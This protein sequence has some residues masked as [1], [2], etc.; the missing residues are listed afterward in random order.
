M[1]RTEWVIQISPNLAKAPT[2]PSVT[3]GPHTRRCVEHHLRW[4]IVASVLVL[5]SGWV[6][7]CMV[8]RSLWF[9]YPKKQ[10]R[11][12][13]GDAQRPGHRGPPLQ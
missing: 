4:P 1:P 12:R 3:S 9:R 2:S 8:H 13:C 6:W 10:P 5:I 11:A 7:S